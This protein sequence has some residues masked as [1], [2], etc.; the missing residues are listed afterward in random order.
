VFCQGIRIRGNPGNRCKDEYEG[1]RKDAEENTKE[2]E[3]SNVP[4]RPDGLTGIGKEGEYD[5]RGN[6]ATCNYEFSKVP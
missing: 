5:E 3:V 1:Y 4:D 2:P 6:H